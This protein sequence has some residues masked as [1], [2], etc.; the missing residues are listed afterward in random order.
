MGTYA[1]NLGRKRFILMQS[2]LHNE[3]NERNN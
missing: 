1:A 3:E 2:I